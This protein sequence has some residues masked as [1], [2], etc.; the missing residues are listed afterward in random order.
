MAQKLH[1]GGQTHNLRVCQCRVQPCQR[2]L[3]R[4]ATHDE[5]GNHAV[6]KRADGIALA[7]AI[8]HAHIADG[9]TAAHG[10]A[11]HLQRAGGGQETVV[12]VLG[13]NPRLDG[14]AN[15]FQL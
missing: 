13:T 12:R 15:D 6:V 1:V 14:V 4:V 7:H 2:L 10:L 9:K 8:V 3:A 11:V 5:L